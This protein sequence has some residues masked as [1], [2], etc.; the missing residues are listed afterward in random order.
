VLPPA[1]AAAVMHQDQRSALE[2]PANL[3]S[4]ARNSAMVFAFQ[5][6]GSAGR[7]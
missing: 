3:P 7:T 4:L 6:S 5:S 2:D 1:F